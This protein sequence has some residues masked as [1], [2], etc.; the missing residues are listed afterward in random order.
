MVFITV[1][2][3][4]NEWMHVAQAAHR[5]WPEEPLER[6]MSRNEACRRFLLAGI[7]KLSGANP[8][9]RR[10][11]ADEHRHLRPSHGDTLLPAE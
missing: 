2:L 6:Q 4:S 11:M 1:V 9:E 8:A 3:D 10:Q 5:H 7:S